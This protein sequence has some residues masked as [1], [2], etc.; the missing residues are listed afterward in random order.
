MTEV[1][2]EVKDA[3]LKCEV[4]EEKNKDQA[5]ELSKAL[6]EAREA[7]TK[8]RATREEIKQAEQIVAG[9]PFLL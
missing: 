8:S 5:V 7:R 9:K 1:E 2:Q 6:Q 4:L 3:P